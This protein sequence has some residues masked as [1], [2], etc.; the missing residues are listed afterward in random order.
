[1]E[2]NEENREFTE[3]TEEVENVE[4]VEETVEESQEYEPQFSDVLPEVEAVEEPK[5][6]KKFPLQVPVIIAACILVVAIIGFLAVSIFTPTVEGT[7]L[8]ES[9]DGFKFYYTFDETSDSNECVMS[10]GTVYFPGFYET[11]VSEDA[12][13]VSVSVYAGYVN[14][15][16]TYDIDGVRLFGNRVLTLTGEDGTVLTLTQQKKPKDSDYIKPDKN[17]EPVE[18]LVGEWEFLYEEFGESY[19]LTI[20]DDGTMVFDQFGLQE[21][22]FTY[23]ADDSKINLSFF[24]TESI[25]QEEEYYFKD[26]QLIFLGLNWSRAGE[27][28]ADQA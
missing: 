19:K 21:I 16:Y 11:S 13:S 4:I 22:H 8:Y 26:N 2:Y 28:T 18:E 25:N 6:K 14:G 23:T 3:A 9:E 5:A 1:M 20:N 15:N 7:W 12:K 17:F 24:E 27:S 10:L